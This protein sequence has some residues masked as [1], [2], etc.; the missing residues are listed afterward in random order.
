MW[1]NK[2]LKDLNSGNLTPRHNQSIP[3]RK[4]LVGKISENIHCDVIS[5]EIRRHS[6]K[7]HVG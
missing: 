6:D 2:I 1:E 4:H 5:S 3:M 7:M